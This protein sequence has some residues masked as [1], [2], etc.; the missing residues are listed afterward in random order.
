MLFA[1]GFGTRM[2]ALT[3]DQPKPMIRV[4]G[5]TLLDHALAL[6]DDAGIS[7]LV[8]NV[9]YLGDQI[10]AHLD[11]RDVAISW[12]KDRILDTGG[13]L[14][15]A[16]P[17]LGPGPVMTLNTDA[18]WTGPNPLRALCDAWDDTKMDALLLLAPKSRAVGHA[19]NG[20]FTLDGSGRIARA[21][22]AEGLVYLGAQILQPGV[23]ASFAQEAFSVNAVWDQMI[24]AK[25]AFGR[26]YDGAW[27][28]VGRPDG[29]GLAEA[30]LAGAVR[31]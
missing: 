22:G 11:G 20:D 5:Q 27:C 1:A 8:V 28:D 14:R 7:R 13:G 23:L 16:L 3:R 25:R 18:V 31:V 2:G 10:A 12:E 19:G 26:V 6:A 24:D 17:L 29:I 30:L 4:A 21:A 15:Q 9:H